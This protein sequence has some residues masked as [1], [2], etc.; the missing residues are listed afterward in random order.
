MHGSP[1]PPHRRIQAK[2]YKL[3]RVLRDCE[4]RELEMLI[5]YYVNGQDIHQVS[6]SMG[7]TDEEFL[8]L[9]RRLRLVTMRE[10]GRGSSSRG[11]EAAVGN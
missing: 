8:R 3:K 10:K 11:A 9:A 2:A 4:K 1:T 7:A 6:E 5:R